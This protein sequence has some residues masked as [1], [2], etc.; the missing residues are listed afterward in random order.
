LWI[1]IY[2]KPGMSL[3]LLCH[4]LSSVIYRSGKHSIEAKGASEHAFGYAS[5]RNVAAQSIR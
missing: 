2:G 4:F 1:V 5:R 3:D